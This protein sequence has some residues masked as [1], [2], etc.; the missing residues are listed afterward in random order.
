MK[1]HLM[2]RI[3]MK[4]P[5]RSA[6]DKATKPA[7]SAGTPAPRGKG[8]AS[9]QEVRKEVHRTQVPR[10]SQRPAERSGQRRSGKP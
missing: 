9:R 3:N 1:F 10:Q 2:E 6:K 7:G 8:T 5:A 4:K